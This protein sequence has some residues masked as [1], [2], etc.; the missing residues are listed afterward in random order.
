MDVYIG[1]VVVN[2]ANFK[3]HLASLEQEFLR[4][5]KHSHK[6]NPTKCAFRVL[7][8]NFLVHCELSW[9]SEGLFAIIET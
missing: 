5:R 3:E 2:S 1:D 9:Q 4:M 6:M 7:V 8:G